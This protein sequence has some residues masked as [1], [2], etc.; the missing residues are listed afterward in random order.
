MAVFGTIISSVT[1]QRWARQTRT[2]PGLEMNNYEAT[3]R[4]I[5]SPLTMDR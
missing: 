3:N 1:C 4:S 2:T 5:G